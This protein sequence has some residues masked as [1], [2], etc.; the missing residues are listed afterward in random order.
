MGKSEPSLVKCQGRASV[1]PGENVDEAKLISRQIAETRV[2]IGVCT[3]LKS[4]GVMMRLG[5][6]VGDLLASYEIKLV[7]LEKQLQVLQQK[8]APRVAP[9]LA[10]KPALAVQPKPAM[11]RPT[12]TPAAPVAVA[13]PA[14]APAVTPGKTAALVPKAAPAK[15]APAK[16]AVAPAKAAVAP[17]KPVASAQKANAPKSRAR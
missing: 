7:D 3:R 16:A 11:A 8:P 9:A 12:T 14:K 2:E 5:K 6:P 15:A 4:K 10:P 17:A 13:A 1:P